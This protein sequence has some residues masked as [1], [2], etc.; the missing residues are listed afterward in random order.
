MNHAVGQNLV[1]LMALTGQQ[2]NI[3]RPRVGQG[4][5]NGLDPVFHHLIGGAAL[6]QTGP[7]YPG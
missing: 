1:G 3:A 6:R 7:V 5:A 4:E 2:D